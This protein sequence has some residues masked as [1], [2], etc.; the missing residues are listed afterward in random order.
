MFGYYAF[1]PKRCEGGN[2][3]QSWI[4]IISIEEFSRQNVK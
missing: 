2:K 1:N 4:E 3:K